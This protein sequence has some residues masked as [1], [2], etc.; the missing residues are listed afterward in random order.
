MAKTSKLPFP[1]LAMHWYA[2][3]VL[4]GTIV[5]LCSG[6]LV[7]SKGAGLAVPDWPTSY[8]YNMFTFPISRWVGGVLYE[9]AHRLIASGV[10]LLFFGLTVWMLISEPRR[11]VKILSIIASF[12]VLLQGLL[13]GLRVTLLKN[14]I[15]IVHGT[16]A[17][18]LLLTIGI[19]F[20]VTSPVWFSVRWSNWGNA[21]ALRRISLLVTGLIF[22]QLILGASMRHEHAGLSIPDF[23]AAYGQLWPPMDAA[24]IEAINAR[25]IE[26]N[27]MPTSAH[28]IGLQMVHRLG[29]LAVLLAVAWFAWRGFSARPLPA[30][31]RLVTALLFAC[32]LLQITLGAWTIWSGKAPWVATAHVLLGALLLLGSGLTTFWLFAARRFAEREKLAPGEPAVAERTAVPRG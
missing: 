4:L 2:G 11:W 25:R 6:G 14:D 12:G 30:S 15:G 27:Q 3:L 23:P 10:G 20:L 21:A 19:L 9:H 28:Q 32:V 5:L 13:G 17:Q 22:V 16:L 8:G 26:E 24:S 1:R 18:S 31:L 7:T 29:A